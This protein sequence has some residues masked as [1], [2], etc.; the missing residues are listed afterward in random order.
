MVRIND[1]KESKIYMTIGINGKGNVSLRQEVEEG[2]VGAVRRDWEVNGEKGT[3]WELTPPSLEGYISGIEIKKE[4]TKGY[5]DRIL[6]TF[7]NEVVVSTKTTSYFGQSLM[8]QLPGVDFTKEVKLTPYSYIPKGKTEE[9]TG[10]SLRQGEGFEV[11]VGDQFFDFENK[12]SLK[13][14]PESDF[15]WAT[16]EKWQKD[17]YWADLD[18]FLKNYITENVVPTIPAFES[19]KSSV[20]ENSDYSSGGEPQFPDEDINPEDI[21][22]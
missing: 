13:G 11:K 19:S 1:T 15:D 18:T 6:V 3:K 20:V 2:T 17:K 7:E 21:P 4:E 14:I 12:K 8:R 22:F 16:V 9:S 10:V 5:G